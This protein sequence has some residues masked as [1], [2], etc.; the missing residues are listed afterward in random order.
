MNTSGQNPYQIA[1]DSIEVCSLDHIGNLDNLKPEHNEPCLDIEYSYKET[2]KCIIYPDAQ[3]L[4]ENTIET[5]N[6]NETGM[7]KNGSKIEIK[8]HL[9]LKSL[10]YMASRQLKVKHHNPF[11]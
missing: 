1:T 5:V 6:Q 9:E 11:I 4:G 7:P 8:T 2:V 3:E 10:A